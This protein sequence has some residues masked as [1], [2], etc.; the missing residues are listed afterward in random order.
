M[1]ARPRIRKRAHFPPNLH[2]PRPGYFTWRDPRDGKT[3]VLGRIPAAEAIH[4]AHEA[5]LVVARG[6]PARTLAER[7]EKPAE[8][9]ADLIKKMPTEGI[10]HNT[11]VAR[12]GYDRV[13]SGAIGHIE[14]RALTTKDVA[15]M[16][17]VVKDKGTM[18]Y[19]EK[20]RTRINAIC[21]KGMALGWME[22]NPAAVTE[23]IKRRVIRRR[24]TLAEFNAILAKA[25][26]VADWLPNAMLL[27]LVSGQD[28]S[29]VARWERSFVKGDVAV[30]QRSKTEVRIAIP[31]AIRMDAIGMSLADVIMR[32]KATGVVSK[33]LIH[34]VRSA[35]GARRGDPVRLS[36]ISNAFAEAREK[37]GI[38]GADVPTFHEIRS[39]CKRLYMEQGGIDTKALLGHMT[40]AIADL[41][42]N[43]RGLEPI[44]VRIG[45]A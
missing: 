23:K 6:A 22:K 17:E 43:S 14:C 19:A 45:G 32:C 33:F 35:G 39:L 2:E 34:H 4:E 29:T 27:A 18:A 26:E 21:C 1:A 42:A 16:L 28:R 37:A 8:T 31:T 36:T 24:L 20:L 5:N 15:E 10:K 25:P 40:D 13:I 30:L 38:L 44:K 11:V 9:I 41:Y 12:A 7:V 3:H